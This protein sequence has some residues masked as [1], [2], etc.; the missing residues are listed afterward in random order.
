MEELKLLYPTP[1]YE[2]PSLDPEIELFFNF[3]FENPE[4]TSTIN[5]RSFIFPT[6]SLQTQTQELDRN[7][8]NLLCNFEDDCKDGCHCLHIHKV[9]YK[10]TVRLVIS[11]VGNRLLRGSHPVHLHGH[12][13]HVVARGYG[14]YSNITGA[15]EESSRDLKC[16]NESI[17]TFCVKPQW[18]ND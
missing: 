7:K 5:G 3:A 6:A 13:F 15:I 10:K 16:G 14:T 4:R 12:S 1:D 2:L 11:T 17:D 8:E 18:A 9:P